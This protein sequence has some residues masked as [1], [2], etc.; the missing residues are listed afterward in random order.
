[1]ETKISSLSMPLRNNFWGEWGRKGS[2]DTSYPSAQG[3][4]FEASLL[5]SNLPMILLLMVSP[6]SLGSLYLP[7]PIP[8][9]LPQPS[10]NRLEQSQEALRAHPAHLTA[11]Q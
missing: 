11:S 5:Y 3:L 2:R 8:R 1:M 7:T 4:A 9:P 10:T 6:S